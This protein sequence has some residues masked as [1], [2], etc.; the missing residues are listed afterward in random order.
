VKIAIT[1]AVILVGAVMVSLAYAATE[2][3][4]HQEVVGWRQIAIR[5]PLFVL[6]GY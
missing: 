1:V 2:Y 6:V 5:S 3:V 4:P